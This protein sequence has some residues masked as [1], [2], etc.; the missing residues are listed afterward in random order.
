MEAGCAAGTGSELIATHLAGLHQIMRKP[1][2]VAE[3][4]RDQEG[5]GTTAQALP[6]RDL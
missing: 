1:N 3:G 6:R 5:L 4:R 2:P